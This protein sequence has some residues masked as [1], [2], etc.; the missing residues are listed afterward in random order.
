MI[1]IKQ[2]I[3]SG[4][5]EEYVLGK[6]SEQERAEVECL[7][8]TY[9]EISKEVEESLISLTLFAEI[10]ATDPKPELKEKI[11][12]SILIETKSENIIKLQQ[13]E[14]TANTSAEKSNIMNYAVAAVLAIIAIGSSYWAFQTNS[15][16]SKAEMEIAE[17]NTA[18]KNIVSDFTTLKDIINKNNSIYELP[19][20]QVIKLEGV[21]EKSPESMAFAVWDKESGNVYLDVKKLPKN[22]DGK[23]YQL[24]TISD[25]GQPISVGVF[26]QSGQKEII[27]LGRAETSIMFAVT[28]EKAG[29]VESPTMSEM[30]ISGKVKS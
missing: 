24:W 9:P 1:D 8:T 13:S 27:N 30:Y 16:L 7:S 6:L 17:L 29:G 26:D 15:Q 12:E 18:N 2:Y 5:I 4:V 11:W 19:K 3:E 23:Q 21:A 22:P 28:L 10:G 14:G 25:K 20:A